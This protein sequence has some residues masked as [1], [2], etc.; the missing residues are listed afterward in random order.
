MKTMNDTAHDPLHDFFASEWETTSPS[1]SPHF[2]EAVLRKIEEYRCKAERRKEWL[3][4]LA[5]ISMAVVS[6]AVVALF[7]YPGYKPI[8]SIDW[9]A[10]ISGAGG[11]FRIFS[12]SA[13]Q[14]KEVVIEAFSA[15]FVQPEHVFMSSLFI[16][17]VVLAAALLG[18]DRL[19]RNHRRSFTVSNV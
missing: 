18:L 14:V 4:H 5:C 6:V 7:I 16:Y 9:S 8:A 3:F 12:D 10:A 1:L 13:L 15:L 11:V 19:L 17:L 2:S